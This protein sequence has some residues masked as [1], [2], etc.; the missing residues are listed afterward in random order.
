MKREHVG[1]VSNV[2]ELT[3]FSLPRGWM[4]LRHVG[5]VPHGCFASVF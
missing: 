2:P 5:N 4:T 1:H 3:E